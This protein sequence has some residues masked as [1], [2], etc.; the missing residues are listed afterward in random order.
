MLVRGK[1]WNQMFGN[2]SNSSKPRD[3]HYAFTT[4]Y[5]QYKWRHI[6]KVDSQ[7]QCSSK[8]LTVGREQFSR[9]SAHAYTHQGS[10]TT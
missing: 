6:A 5:F 4:Q 9:E 1:K 2:D 7:T 8:A 3:A 10:P